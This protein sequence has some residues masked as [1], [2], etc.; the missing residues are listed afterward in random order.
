MVTLLPNHNRIPNPYS[1]RDNPD[2][3]LKQGWGLAAGSSNRVELDFTRLQMERSFQL[4][5]TREMFYIDT[6]VDTF[7][8]AVKALMNDHVTIQLEFHKV[9]ELGIEAKIDKME[10]VS[11]SEPEIIFNDKYKYLTMSTEIIVAHSDVVTG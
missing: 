10:I 8:V 4:I 7:D 11:S 6:K 1:L 5:T 3:V 9:N 2:I